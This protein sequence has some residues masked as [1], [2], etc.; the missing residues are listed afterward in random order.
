MVDCSILWIELG[1]G[2]LVLCSLKLHQLPQVA[3][4]L[5]IFNK[6]A[7]ENTFRNKKYWRRLS[8][9]NCNH[10]IIFT[11]FDSNNQTLIEL[12]AIQIHILQS[13]YVENQMKVFV[14]S[15]SYSHVNSFITFGIVFVYD[16]DANFNMIRHR[17]SCKN[18]DFMAFQDVIHVSNISCY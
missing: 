4:K 12:N 2:W 6:C 3:F 11:R 17:S 15:L 5:V 16:K 13:W 9:F 8:G 14:L 18:M 7:L 1:F 10:L